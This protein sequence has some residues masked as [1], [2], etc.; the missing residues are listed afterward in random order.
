MSWVKWP[1]FGKVRRLHVATMGTAEPSGMVDGDAVVRGKL[2]CASFS[3]PSADQAAYGTAAERAKFNID[4]TNPPTAEALR[5]QDQ[6]TGSYFRLTV[7]G[8]AVI[9]TAL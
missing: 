3:C 9:L 2:T 8:G 5:M 6:T 4:G 1:F 7:T